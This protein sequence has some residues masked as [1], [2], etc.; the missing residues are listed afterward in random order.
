MKPSRNPFIRSASLTASIVLCLGQAA[1]AA[2]DTWGADANGEWGTAGSWAGNQVP[3]TVGSGDAGISTTD[4]AIFDGAGNYTVYTA[5]NRGIDVTTFSNTG[6]TTILGGTTTTPAAASLYIF[7]NLSVSAGAGAVTIGDTAAS[8]T[9]QVIIRTGTLS[10]TNNSSN[11]LT[12]AGAIQSRG[13]SGTTT[14]TITGTGNTLASGAVGGGGGA[15]IAL[16]KSGNGTLTL[17]GANIYS[18]ATNVSVGTLNLT[19]S[20]GNSPVSVSGTLSGEGSIGTS[21]SLTFNNGSFLRVNSGT[22]GA[23]TV[24]SGSTGNL[25]LNATT[26]VILEGP[27][28]TTAGTGTSIRL[29]NFNGTLTGTAANLA[30][31]NAAN[32]RNPVFSTATAKQVNLTL[33]TK[34]LTWNG[35]SSAA[36][37]INTTAN[38]NS[39]GENYY[40]GDSVTFDGTSSNLD[41]TLAAAVTP[42]S[43]TF[44]GATNAQSITGAGSISSAGALS[45]SGASTATLA[46]ANS[47]G[48][49]SLDGGTLAYA[50]DGT[51]TGGLIFG[52]TA[53]STNVSTLDL[54]TTPVNLT[55]TGL[56]VQTNSASANTITIGTGKT[57][58]INGNVA[59]GNYA[60]S[61][62]STTKLTATGAG[63]LT[64]NIG[65]G[66]FL[67]GANGSGANT[68]AT[69]V[70]FSGLTTFNLNSTSNASILRLGFNGNTNESSSN[71]LTL[72]ANSS[73]N[74]GTIDLGKNSVTGATHTLNLNAT[75][76]NGIQATTLNLGTGE[77]PTGG[78]RGI[79][80]L[81]FAG[82]GVGT[83]TLSGYGGVGGTNVN[84]AT[85][86]REWQWRRHHRCHGP[87]RQYD[88]RHAQH[89]QFK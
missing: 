48:S 81:K 46:V 85:G 10:Y 58:A 73:I 43:L 79:G 17:S 8:P 29:L 55:A 83:L 88:H 54:Q 61:A 5:G 38:W 11:L 41:V 30:L 32:Y 77:G 1:N 18:G 51:I 2:S 74:V 65:T 66:T 63:T 87:Y 56:T 37:D 70:D 27:M 21:G 4:D 42:A 39:P 50:V 75:G 86:G 6:T 40:Q 22:A 25:T 45:K 9:R 82:A 84:L 49:A 33:D 13:T 47:F 20:M 44:S 62:D 19:G 3:G 23:L 64:T 34:A 16:T 78:G 14:V 71:T 60:P 12:L 89:E 69:T 31:V 67:I 68:V 76:S 80:V 26:N 24:G 72:A 35:T 36:W 57:L 53:A 59:L 15:T 7:G 52:A 28:P